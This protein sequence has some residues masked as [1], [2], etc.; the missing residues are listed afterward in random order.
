MLNLQIIKPLSSGHEGVVYTAKYNGK[1]CIAKVC[2]THNSV[3]NEFKN[4]INFAHDLSNLHNSNKAN[5]KSHI[6][7]MEMISYLYTTDCNC[8]KIK[9]NMYCNSKCKKN[10]DNLNSL[11]NCNIILYTPVLDDTMHNV[12]SI[13]KITEKQ[14]AIMMHQ[15]I[16]GIK[17]LH[18]RGY[19]HN[20]LHSKNI[21]C[22]NNNWYII[23]YGS[24]LTIDYTKNKID[25]TK[26]SDIIDDLLFFTYFLPLN[27]YKHHK[28][29][30]KGKMKMLNGLHRLTDEYYKYMPRQVITYLEKKTT[31]NLHKCL[32]KTQKKLMKWEHVAK[33]NIYF[34]VNT[35]MYLI[36]TEL[37]INIQKNRDQPCEH[38]I[39]YIIKHIYDA[40]ILSKA[41]EMLNNNYAE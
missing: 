26:Y 41:L 13:G 29:V 25:N 27:S 32:F 7:F 9:P 21:M 16:Y 33:E 39:L 17:L 38:I 18:D 35:I 8:E 31:E 36:D 5:K 12:L 15:I 23:D 6:P 20:D 24:I 4:E 19:I 28:L 2:R 11:T 1:K 22:K 3:S 14:F 40:N 34:I 37:P 10:I 30:E